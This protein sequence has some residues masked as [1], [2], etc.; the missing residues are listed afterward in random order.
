VTHPSLGLPPRN[1]K[2]GFPAAA[3]ALR[4]SRRRIAARALEAAIEIDPTIAERYDE[5]GLRKLLHDAEVLLDRVADS[6]ASND[7]HVTASW[8]D[9]VVPLY[10]RRAVPMD[11][12]VRLCEG[13]RRAIAAVLVPGEQGPVHAALDEAIRVFRWHRRLAGDARRRNRILAAIYKGA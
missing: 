10:R 6:V 5:I 2:A 11:D 9:Q 13:L 3:A 4:A 7:P 1:M 12:L 8:A